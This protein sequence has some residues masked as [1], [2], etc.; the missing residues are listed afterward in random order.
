MHYSR[1]GFLVPTFLAR[2]ASLFPS[3]GRRAAHR[4]LLVLA[5]GLGGLGGVAITPTAAYADVPAA[6]RGTTD[7]IPGDSNR[8]LSPPPLTGFSF[9][10]VTSTLLGGTGKPTLVLNLMSH[11]KVVALAFLGTFLMLEVVFAGIFDGRKAPSSTGKAIGLTIAMV[12]VIQNFDIVIDAF[13]RSA[14]F[15]SELVHEAVQT[16]ASQPTDDAIALARAD[17]SQRADQIVAQYTALSVKAQ[18]AKSDPSFALDGTEQAQLGQLQQYMNLGSCLGMARQAPPAQS[19][20][21]QRTCYE[22]NYRKGG[23]MGTIQRIA[24]KAADVLQAPFDLANEVVNYSIIK[25]VSWVVEWVIGAV[26]LAAG[27]FLATLFAAACAIGPMCLALVPFRFGRGA[28]SWWFKNML[29]LTLMPFVLALST[30]LYYGGVDQLAGYNSANPAATLVEYLVL[31][32]TTIALVKIGWQ[33]LNSVSGGFVAAGADIAAVAGKAALAVGTA[34]VGA[35]ASAG[36]TGAGFMTRASSATRAMGGEFARQTGSLAGQWSSSMLPRSAGPM[37]GETPMAERSVA[38]LA[39]AGADRLAGNAGAFASRA[40][41]SSRRAAT[42]LGPTGRGTLEEPGRLSSSSEAERMAG[43]NHAGAALA[44]TMESGRD[45]TT[46]GSGKIRLT[47]AG[48][49]AVGALRQTGGARYRTTAGMSDGDFVNHPAVAGRLLRTH[50]SGGSGVAVGADGSADRTIA[51]MLPPALTAPHNANERSN[52]A[53]HTQ[54][55]AGMVQTIRQQSGGSWSSVQAQVSA[56]QRVVGRQAT[57]ASGTTYGIDIATAG[58]STS[59]SARRYSFQAGS[60]MDMELR[61]NPGISQ[62]AAYQRAA[63]RVRQQVAQESGESGTAYTERV[64]RYV[65]LDTAEAHTPA[66]V[67]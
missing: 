39:A 49:R 48:A 35:F 25:T 52:G 44:S 29:A 40:M 13:R 21:V 15:G 63:N 60:H 17:G 2:I 43:L 30:G 27:A 3:R 67:A 53:S 26:T 54:R 59:P 28:G 46:D 51:E 10:C 9:S 18:K 45:Y 24:S 65:F 14:I 64:H 57:S 1:P 23:V 37:A 56:L 36:A 33:A 62:E 47:E 34:G 58:P 66:G 31:L 32:A 50:A 38:R 8:W 41:Q 5:L 12:L 7:G 11:F 55:V 4:T 42:A 6:C 19:V 20:V 16:S 61:S 22:L